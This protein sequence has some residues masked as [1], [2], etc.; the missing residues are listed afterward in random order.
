[1]YYSENNSLIY[2]RGNETVMIEPWGANALRVRVTYNP[3]FTG[4]DHALE[5][6]ES[7]AQVEVGEMFA[8]ITNGKISCRL[9][10]SGRLKFFKDGQLILK[11]YSRDWSSANGHSPS[12]K[13]SARELKPICGSDYNITMRFEADSSEKI[14]GMGQYQQPNLDLKGCIL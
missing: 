7:K 4:V 1:M 14:F 11:E 9:S 6:V 13:V 3:G 8:A 2:R 12:M 5:R 10:K